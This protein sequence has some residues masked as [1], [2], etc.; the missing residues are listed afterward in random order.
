MSSSIYGNTRLINQQEDE[1]VLVDLIGVFKRNDRYYGFILKHLEALEELL[2]THLSRI[3]K[4]LSESKRTNSGAGLN[5]HDIFKKFRGY[6]SKGKTLASRGKGLLSKGIEAGSLFGKK[7]GELAGTIGKS[8]SKFISPL[9]KSG[10]KLVGKALPGAGLAVGLGTTAM[11]PGEGTLETGID[12]AT[13]TASGAATGAAVGALFG[14]VGAVPGAAIGAAVG[15]IGTYTARNW[16]EVKHGLEAVTTGIST[17]AEQASMLKEKLII[18]GKEWTKGAL[19]NVSDLLKVSGNWITDKFSQ[20][21]STLSSIWNS[22]D[23]EG[24]F[25][26]IFNYITSL[27]KLV[28][29]WFTRSSP[30]EGLKDSGGELGNS[31]SNPGLMGPDSESVGSGGGALLSQRQGTKSSRKFSEGASL[32]DRVGTKSPRHSYSEEIMPSDPNVKVNSPPKSADGT[33]SQEGLTFK[34]GRVGRD[35]FTNDV[36]GAAQKLKSLHGD[37]VITGGTEGGHAIHGEH[38]KGNA[39]DIRINGLSNDERVKLVENARRAGFTGIGL[40]RDHLHLDMRN[41]GKGRPVVFFE[42]GGQAVW[43]GTKKDWTKALEGIAPATEVSPKSELQKEGPTQS[44]PSQFPLD[45]SINTKKGGEPIQSGPS[46]VDAV[47]APEVNS[48]TPDSPPAEEH[49]STEPEVKEKQ[50]QPKTSTTQE[51]LVMLDSEGIRLYSTSD[52]A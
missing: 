9:L 18:K 17:I 27:T 52:F 39:I 23:I 16:E 44:L 15:A 21:K 42:P 26:L 33:V 50:E 7:A 37:Y 28:S 47:N 6:G 22:I 35:G 11:M 40:A 48:K 10:A 20:F 32:L 31:S 2:L 41:G 29:K 4:L 19:K 8:A 13:N 1:R 24:K 45:S 3:N 51:D 43:G 46:P 34:S 38:P 49:Q 14:G 36:M 5:F 30:T 12:Y 25:S